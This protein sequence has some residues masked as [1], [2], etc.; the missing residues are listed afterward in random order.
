MEMFSLCGFFVL[1]CFFLLDWV[2]AA[3]WN[4]IKSNMRP[5]KNF[6]KYSDSWVC[7]KHSVS[8][9]LLEKGTQWPRCF[10]FPLNWPELQGHDC[11]VGS[12]FNS[13]WNF[14]SILIVGW[15]KLGVSF[16]RR[17]CKG[18]WTKYILWSFWNNRVYAEFIAT[19]CGTFEKKNIPLFY[20]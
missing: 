4:L 8:C 6:W 14:T 10:P 11:N 5:G 2:M 16:H 17:D 19:I 20:L 1:V 12:P 13:H 15:F 18:Y 3:E 7:Y 9:Y